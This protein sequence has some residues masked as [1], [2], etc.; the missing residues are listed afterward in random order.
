MS[1]RDKNTLCVIYKLLLLAV[2]ITAPEI[3]QCTF[4]YNLIH[5]NPG[6]LIREK[7]RRKRTLITKLDT[8]PIPRMKNIQ[9]Q[10]WITSEFRHTPVGKDRFSPASFS[11][12]FDRNHYADKR[13]QNERTHVY[14]LSF[15]HTNYNIMYEHVTVKY[16]MPSPRL[17][18]WLM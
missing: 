7:K 6:W 2:T 3:G 12:L 5:F 9:L 10:R 17:W 18:R 14:R 15:P 13:L 16:N 4:L 11:K 8:T 1:F